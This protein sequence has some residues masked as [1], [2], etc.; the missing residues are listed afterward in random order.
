MGNRGSVPQ[1]DVAR[2]VAEPVTASSGH[3]VDEG[4]STIP[5][6]G[7]LGPDGKLILSERGKEAERKRREIEANQRN[8]RPWI[9]PLDRYTLCIKR[10]QLEA[11]SEEELEE[12]L[13]HFGVSQYV[14]DDAIID[15]DTNSEKVFEEF[16]HKWV[17]LAIR[18]QVL[19]IDVIGTSREDWE[20]A[21]AYAKGEHC[22]EFLEREEASPRDERVGGGKRK[23]SKK[24]KSKR[25]SKGKKSKKRKT[26]RRRR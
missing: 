1:A 20:A 4:Q 19:G 11:M 21:E 22:E 16:K 10:R 7:M 25:K 15:E 5:L 17:D 23:K 26:R 2:P 12:E 24:R 6:R 9:E 14:I 13:Q 8:G 18:A 3:S